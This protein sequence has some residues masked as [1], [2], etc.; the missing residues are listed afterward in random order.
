MQPTQDEMKKRIGEY[1]K[2]IQAQPGRAAP[3]IQLGLL[4]ERTGQLDEA[5]RIFSKALEIQPGNNY[6][7]GRLKLIETPEDKA[8]VRSDYQFT[9][10]KQKDR[11]NRGI[12]LGF[13]LVVLLI[14]YVP[15]KFLV[16][17]DTRK[18]V[19][20]GN[21][22]SF[23]QWSP[24]RRIFSFQRIKGNPSRF[25][26]LTGGNLYIADA[27]AENARKLIIE[28]P[29]K[30]WQ[31]DQSYAW[32]C[33][34]RYL[35]FR[36]SY[37]QEY[38]V[39]VYDTDEKKLIRIQPGLNPVWS[40]VENKVAFQ[41]TSTRWDNSGEIVVYDVETNQSKRIYSGKCRI[42][43]WS[44]DG[45]W[46]VFDERS[47]STW[48]YRLHSDILKVNISTLETVQLTSDEKC[49]YPIWLPDNSGIL[50]LFENSGKEM[51]KMDLNGKNK[52]RL[53]SAE[54]GFS[55]DLTVSPNSRWIAF[56]R[57]F[58]PE[59]METDLED[60]GKS[61]LVKDIFV[62]RT[63]GTDIHRLKNRHDAKQNPVF[64]HN[65]KWIAYHVCPLGTKTQIWKTKVK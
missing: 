49:M 59:D 60:E 56:T 1:R 42:M 27:N 17:P 25:F 23:P 46:L 45:Q 40:P 63:N 29:D 57:G 19:V 33:K 39:C 65:S 11:I 48:P 7:R 3:Y 41:K 10:T 50:F 20:D 31:P 14:I 52:Q 4:L 21:H 47:Y 22:N 53:Y 12:R 58:I 54:Y 44:P 8:N 43:S 30:D 15:I 28:D 51:W 37:N 16:F 64:S 61:S 24:D 2:L 38:S 26:S 18:M 32:S 34:S 5:K 13:L 9:S 35:A 6:I 62:A 55:E 36:R